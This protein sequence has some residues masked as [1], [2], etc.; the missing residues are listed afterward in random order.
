M[1]IKWSDIPFFQ[2]LSS[3]QIGTIKNY[4]TPVSFSKD[5]IVIEEG[6]TGDFML[7]LVQGEVRVLKNMILK[8]AAINLPFLKDTQKVLAIL[9]SSRYPI[10][11]EIALLD[12][13]VRSASVITTRD[14]I[15]LKITRSDF[16]RLVSTEPEL[17]LSIVLVLG[18]K[19]AQRLRQANEDIIKL[20][21]AMALVL[22][23]E[24]KE[25]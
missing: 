14:S 8:E 15:F 17:A 5:K 22:G 23:K 16:M 1:E 21:T 18:Q 20:T 4:F 11:G 25:L 10:F 24:K 12:N 6:E 13:D 3:S 7:I 19:I 9:D 2:N